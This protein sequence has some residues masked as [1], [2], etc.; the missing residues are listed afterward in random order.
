MVTLLIA[1]DEEDVRQ[2]ILELIPWARN[3]VKLCPAAS[4]GLEALDHVEIYNPDIILIDV[5]MPKKSGLDVIKA[6]AGR[7]IRAI[8]LSGYNEAAQAQEAI[9]YGAQDCLLKPCKP[10]D[11]L[12]AVLKQRDLAMSVKEVCV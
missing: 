10:E 7:R 11:I 12:A 6:L 3:G 1:D 9:Q 4:D 5:S 8:M 2:T